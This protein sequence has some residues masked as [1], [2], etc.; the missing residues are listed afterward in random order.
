MPLPPRGRPRT[1]VARAEIGLGHQHGKTRWNGHIDRFY[2]RR[3]RLNRGQTERQRMSTD[4]PPLPGLSAGAKILDIRST[5]DLQ[6][7]AVFSFSFAHQ[8]PQDR[9]RII[10]AHHS[11]HLHQGL[12]MLQRLPAAG[13]DQEAFCDLNG[14]HCFRSQ[15]SGVREKRSFPPPQR[16][17]Q[18]PLF[19]PTSRTES[20]AVHCGG[21]HQ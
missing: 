12:G 3:L 20:H 18:G 11:P 15:E 1:S 19:L 13:V 5:Q 17:R 4:R 9:R 16:R 14:R 2:W 10:E 21:L 7:S 8:A 6:T